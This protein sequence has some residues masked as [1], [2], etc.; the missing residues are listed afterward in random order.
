MRDIKFIQTVC[1][2]DCG[3][4]YRTDWVCPSC[5]SMNDLGFTYE[6]EPPLGHIST[7][8]KCKLQITK[9]QMGDY[10]DWSIKELN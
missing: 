8:E 2:E 3:E 9:L 5:G 7:C 1:C 6:S 4:V 10:W